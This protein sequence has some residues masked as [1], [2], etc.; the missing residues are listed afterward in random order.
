MHSGERSVR[1]GVT[2]STWTT[3][4]AT[5]VTVKPGTR[6]CLTWWCKTEGLNKA[7]AYLFLQTNKAQRVFPETDMFRTEDWTLQL[8]E[9]RTTE[10]EEWLY[11]ICTM[12]D[13][14]GP[15]CFTWFDDLAIY[16]GAF[17][18]EQEAIWAARE[19]AVRG[20]SETATFYHGINPW[21]EIT[22]T[23]YPVGRDRKGLYY[24]DAGEA[25]MLYPNPR[26]TGGP[27]VNAVQPT[28]PATG[29]EPVPWTAGTPAPRSLG[30]LPCL[31]LKLLKKGIDDFEYLELYRK[32]K[33]DAA[34]REAAE[35]LVKDI[36][37][38]ELDTAIL[39]KARDRIAREIEKA[40]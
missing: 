4:A 21:E 39:E 28:G 33:G 17:P 8:A 7:R 24:Y 37:K 23:P 1:L 31:R 19:R 29:A 2:P 10:D 32:A 40:Q 27:P 18:P 12:Q 35:T 3:C 22:P 30:V 16:E 13:N 36:G 20:I 11:P 6:Y 15:E 34:M 9:Y 14:A 26:R 5:P 25:I 38:Y